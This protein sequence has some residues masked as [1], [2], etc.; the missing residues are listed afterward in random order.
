M[1]NHNHCARGKI[2]VDDSE[3]TNFMGGIVPRSICLACFDTGVIAFAFWLVGKFDIEA[4]V[5]ATAACTA[6]VIISCK[7]ATRVGVRKLSELRE[8][9]R[10]RRRDRL[11][12][13]LRDERCLRE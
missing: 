8:R 12:R 1:E 9:R 11:R 6:C 13:G 4:A 5:A 3:R 7:P 10:D 2:V